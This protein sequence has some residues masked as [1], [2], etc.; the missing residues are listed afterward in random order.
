[1]QEAKHTPG[2]WIVTRDGPEF[3]IGPDCNA[4]RVAI[5][6]GLYG[7]TDDSTPAHNSRLISAAPELLEALRS[8]VRAVEERNDAAMTMHAGYAASVL[9][10]AA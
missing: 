10:K 5:V 2:P 1:M 3:L 8:L 6:H 4:P 7:D 9:V